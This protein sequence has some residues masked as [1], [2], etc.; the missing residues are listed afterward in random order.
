MPTSGAGARTANDRRVRRDVRKFGCHVVS[1]FDPRGR[2][3]YFSY[4]IGIRESSGAPDIIVIGLRPELGGRL[5]N[6]YNRQLRAGKRFR[7]GRKYRGF[8]EGFAVL[9]EPARHERFRHYTFGCARYYG[10]EEYEVVQL[11]W[12]STAGVWPWNKSASKW[13]VRNQPMLGRK[14]P[15]RP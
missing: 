8:L 4:S 3:P 10:H 2:Q 7:R 15:D 6:E 11:V 5:V 12:P 14:R 1:V 9:F 13:L